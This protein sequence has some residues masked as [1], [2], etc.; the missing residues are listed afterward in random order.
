MNYASQQQIQHFIRKNLINRQQTCLLL[1]YG[2]SHLYCLC[3]D[4]AVDD[5]AMQFTEEKRTNTAICCS[6]FKRQVFITPHY[7]TTF[8]FFSPQKNELTNN[9]TNKQINTVMSVCPLREQSVKVQRLA[10]TGLGCRFSVHK[11]Y[12]LMEKAGFSLKPM[13]SHAK[14]QQLKQLVAVAVA[15]KQIF[16]LIPN[17][18]S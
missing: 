12:C 11:P 5:V 15:V 14:W 10:G 17:F 4:E 16:I 6:R 1:P 7:T 13:K 9:Q 8:L 18:L 3:S 2:G